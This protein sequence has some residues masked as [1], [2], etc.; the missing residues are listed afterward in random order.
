M[1]GEIMKK[2]PIYIIAIFAIVSVTAF[3]AN[4]YNAFFGRRFNSE[5][6]FAY[7]DK[8][9]ELTK[10]LIKSRILIGK[11]KEQVKKILGTDCKGCSNSTHEWM[12]ADTWMYYTKMEKDIID[13]RIRVLDI[14][15]VGD[16]VTNVQERSFD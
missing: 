16:V 12:K 7:P 8:R 5:R 3:V 1:Q 14:Y 4:R 6:W 15:F 13:A 2:I 11:P 9:F 10:D